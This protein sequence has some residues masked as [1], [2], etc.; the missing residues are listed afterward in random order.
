MPDCDK[1]ERSI[2]KPWRS[3]CRL[4]RGNEN[5]PDQALADEV[6]NA[7]RQDIKTIY[8][9]PSSEFCNAVYEALAPQPY[10]PFGFDGDTSLRSRH[11][12]TNKLEEIQT[13]SGNTLGSQ[14]AA[15]TARLVF[16]ELKSAGRRTRPKQVKQ[17]FSDTFLWQVVDQAFLSRVRDPLM[18]E[19]GRTLNDQEPIPIS[20][21]SRNVQRSRRWS[22]A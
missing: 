17:A 6:V 9:Y 3:A 18:Q 22:D 15:K 4:A 10:L 19:T 11:R 20:D 21:Q 14:V 1:L 13:Q 5:L 7:A 16:D 8:N 12:L 2:G